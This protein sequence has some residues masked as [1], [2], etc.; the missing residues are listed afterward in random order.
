MRT[1]FRLLFN[2][3]VM[4]CIANFAITATVLDT[5]FGANGLKTVIASLLLDNAYPVAGYAITPAMFALTR[6]KPNDAQTALVDPRVLGVSGAAVL[7]R[8]VGQQLLVAY[9]SGGATASPTTPAAPFVTAGATP[10]TSSAA[11]GVLTP[12]IGKDLANAS[13]LSAVTVIVQVQG[14]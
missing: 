10:V 13:D 6:F 8:I 7:P 5:N 9:P 2:L 3:F 11:T 14:Y 1:I 12:G 4:P